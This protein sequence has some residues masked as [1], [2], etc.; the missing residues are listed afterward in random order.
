[1]ATLQFPDGFVWGVATSAYQ[2]E[3]GWDEDGR[4][5]SIWD[6]FAKTPDRAIA[7]DH[8][9]RWPE[10]VAL[11]KELGIQA[12]RFSMS[13]PRILPDGKGRVNRKGL[14]FY[15]RLVDDLLK[16]GITPFVTL[17]HWELPQ[18]L[19]DAGGW[20][21]LAMP[22]RYIEAAKIANQGVRLE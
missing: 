21:S 6:T 1:M 3:G 18:V 16:A 14:D 17:Y 9:H 19:Q 10:D 5:P 20:A 7:C 4:T 12:Y 15:S 8:Y 13:W 22:G 11:M 2:I